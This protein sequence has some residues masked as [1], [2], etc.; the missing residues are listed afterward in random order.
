MAYPTIVHV[1]E[2]IDAGKRLIN[3][4]LA[5]WAKKCPTLP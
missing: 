5:G 4:A 3:E 1:A 2:R